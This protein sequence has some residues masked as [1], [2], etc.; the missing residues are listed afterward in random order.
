MRKKIAIGTVNFGMAYGVGEGCYQVTRQQIEQ[1]LEYCVDQRL[2]LFDTAPAYGNSECVLGEICPSGAKIV[3]KVVKLEV[4]VVTENAIQTLEDGLQCSLKQLSTSSVYGLLVHNVDDL[5]KLGAEKIVA[6]MMG[7]KERGLVRKIGVSAYSLAEVNALYTKH[8]FD[9]VQL[10][11]NL[12]DQRFLASGTLD[13]LHD[14]GVEI[15]ARSLFMKG[16]LLKEICPREADAVLKAHHK[17]FL[18]YLVHSSLHAFDVCMMFATSLKVVD[19]WVL[20]FSK[21]AQLKEVVEWKETE[22]VRRV[23]LS[24]WSLDSHTSVDPRTWK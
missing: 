6:W 10:P 8:R 7:L 16:L 9:L 5:F 3:T 17:H 15:H 12:F 20:G 14:S 23:H 24:K 13:W 11:I 1:M 21:L 18:D 2:D 22:S 4:D 19:R